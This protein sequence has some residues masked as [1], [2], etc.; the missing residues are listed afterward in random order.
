MEERGNKKRK[1]LAGV[2]LAVLI[3][4]FAGCVLMVRRNSQK[5]RETIS[6]N[7]QADKQEQEKPGDDNDKTEAGEET[8]EEQK[9]EE[10]L[11]T[12]LCL[13]EM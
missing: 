13:P 2:M 6:G 7:A 11:P 4:M 9:E 8:N 3:C 1:I 5:D 12:R 10:P